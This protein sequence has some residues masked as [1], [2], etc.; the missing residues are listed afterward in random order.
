[1]DAG[2]RHRWIEDELSLAAFLLHSI[3]AVHGELSEGLAIGRDAIAE[4]NVV[5]GVRDRRDGER[6]QQSDNDQSL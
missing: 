4:H 2:L 1:M 3:V 5:D 6:R